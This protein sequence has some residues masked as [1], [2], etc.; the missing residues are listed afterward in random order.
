MSS[1]PQP[2]EG[3]AALLV[4]AIEEAGGTATLEYLRECV[5]R[6]KG[7]PLPPSGLRRLL[8][9]HPERFRTDGLDNWS[10]VGAT[11]DEEPTPPAPQPLLRHPSP[12][13]VV[14]DFE[15]TGPDPRTCQ[16]IEIGAAV[17]CDG[18]PAGRFGCLVRTEDEVAP[19]VL[20][21]T[22][23]TQDQIDGGRERGEALSEL[24]RF[25]GGRLLVAHNAWGFDQVVLESELERLGL[26][27]AAPPRWADT[28]PIARMLYPPPLLESHSLEVL[29]QHLGV[30]LPPSH[31]A[32]DDVQALVEVVA[33]L[34]AEMSTT[35]DGQIVAALLSLTDDPFAELV[36]LPRP[37]PPAAEA[38]A[39]LATRRLA[40]L[41]PT[42]AERAEGLDPLVDVDAAFDRLELGSMSRRES[43]RTF[44]RAVASRLEEGGVLICE[45]PT[46]TGKSLGY[47]V[48]AIIHSQGTRQ[49]VTVSTYSRELQNQVVEHEAAKLT[50]LLHGRPAICALKG[51]SNYVWIAGLAREVAHALRASELSRGTAYSLGMVLRLAVA[52]TDGALDQVVGSTLPRLADSSGSPADFYAAYEQ[53]VVDSGC[54]PSLSL[55]EFYARAKR[56]AD[57]AD[58]VIVNHALLLTSALAQGDSEGQHRP[59]H[60]IVDEAH[61]LESAATLALTESL[62]ESDLGRIAQ[63]L[64][65]RGRYSLATLARE[66]KGAP[67]EAREGFRAVRELAGGLGTHIVS[68]GDAARQYVEFSASPDDATLRT[69]GATVA[70]SAQMRGTRP[71]SNV[72]TRASQTRRFLQTLAERLRE[73]LDGVEPDSSEQYRR[74][75]RLASSCGRSID[76]ACRLLRGFRPEPQRAATRVC[77]ISVDPGERGKTP[78]RLERV[79]IRVGPAL[80][81]SLYDSAETVVLCS[82]TLTAP[83]RTFDF[84]NDRLGL[85]EVEEERRHALVL[86][87]EFDYP[88]NALLCLPNHLLTPRPERL[89]R[90]YPGVVADELDRLIRLFGGAILGLF[91]AKARRDA[92]HRLLTDRA[93]SLGVN[94]LSETDSGALRRFREEPGTVLLGGPK[95]WTG[96]DVPGEA[97]R[98]VAMSKLPFGRPYDPV[99][100][101]R[102]QDME[103]RRGSD[104]RRAFDLYVLPMMIMSLKQGFGRL[105]RRSTDRG[106]V[107]VLDKRLRWAGYRP[108]VLRALPPARRSMASDIEMYREIN[109]FLDLGVSDGDLPPRPI[110]A[111]EERLAR[112]EMDLPLPADA[113]PEQIGRAMS[114]LQEAAEELLGISRLRSPQYE[115]LQE[116]IMGRDVL[117]VAPTGSGKSLTFQL[118]ALCRRGLTLVISPLISLMRDQAR[119]LADSVGSQWVADI[120]QG[121][122]VVA[123]EEAL[124]RARDGDLRLLYVSPERLQSPKFRDW[125]RGIELAQIVIDEAHCISEWGHDFR[126]QYLRIST[127]TECFGGAPIHALTATAT[128]RVRSD[129]EATLFGEGRAAKARS[130][131]RREARGNLRYAHQK[132]ADL[133]EAI[134]MACAVAESH[135]GQCGIVY[136]RTRANAESVA[137]ALRQSNMRAAHYHGGMSYGRGMVEQRFMSGQLDC[138]A[139]T[140]AFGMG[141]DKADVRYVVHVGPSLS[142]EAYVQETGRA[143][144]DGKDA[145]CLLLSWPGC[146]STC[147]RLLGTKEGKEGLPAKLMG[148]LRRRP[149]DGVRALED[150]ALLISES[151][152]KKAMKAGGDQNT[153]TIC[154]YHLE[155]AGCLKWVEDVDTRSAVVLNG[156]TQEVAAALGEEHVGDFLRLAHRFGFS[157]EETSIVDID[158]CPEIHPLRIGEILA[159]ASLK[160]ALLYRPFE[161]RHLVRL[162][163]K[164]S[165]AEAGRRMGEVASHR[166]AALNRMLEYVDLPDS[167]CRMAFLE[168]YLSGRGGDEPACGRCDHCSDEPLWTPPAPEVLKALEP[169]SLDPVW[170]ILEAVEESPGTVGAHKFVSHLLGFENSYWQGKESPLPEQLRGAY[171]HGILNGMIPP[172]P[173]RKIVESM[174]REGYLA[175]GDYRT[176]ELGERGLRVLEGE[177]EAPTVEDLVAEENEEEEESE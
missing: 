151:A 44:S 34:V 91:T 110:S 13:Y 53:C 17:V 89:N 150:G 160:E 29:S 127:L 99:E 111:D 115:C 134:A 57:E 101:A 172:T 8:E 70:F 135:A 61:E 174:A 16:I 45:A 31:R 140:T 77:T 11:A 112:F 165:A 85:A 12:E 119:K 170:C 19:E 80:A 97:L 1:K 92:V 64:T 10:L 102:G 118:P 47:L 124:K 39:R 148:V 81:E 18:V 3:L 167:Q 78:W 133:T 139:A 106:V 21:L 6:E 74:L 126:P 28:L 145:L 75:V 30:T 122:P 27:P 94:V 144:R 175:K 104:G 33:G 108:Q 25:V 109:R 136:C 37:E 116:V 20:H 123:Q 154:L 166:H 66:W 84:M 63:L 142:I 96:I 107:V 149:R 141:V 157:Q 156:D 176:V 9:R 73:C 83:G 42:R 69:Y 147:Q 60:V 163:G 22:G 43:Q 138:I 132:C 95:L 168:G 40:R 152:V 71:H 59:R 36:G 35:A 130:I 88:S 128:D 55:E 23:L 79:P 48:P 51:M 76:A 137:A 52:S 93:A 100:V 146:G 125:L 65:G 49:S 143:G 54:V 62:A 50:P 15:T 117:F 2:P 164:G 113:S 87:H 82:A 7:R 103:E 177:E 129:I 158:E 155:Q 41:L 4:A 26:T 171:C 120:T 86:D 32:E 67:A 5:A 161:R 159:E 162:T 173:L 38:V 121:T 46:G 169:E 105:L 72:L 68:L 153:V 98:C 58:V 56:N 114:L 90:D 24:L 131:I 14:I